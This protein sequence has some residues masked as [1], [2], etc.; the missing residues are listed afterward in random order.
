MRKRTIT[1]KFN[2]KIGPR[3]ALLKSLARALVLNERIETT[4][5]KAKQLSSFIEK[6]I[7]LAR[8]GDLSAIRQLRKVFS[9][10]VTNKLVKDIAPLYKDRE[11]GYTRITKLGQRK[12]D[13]SNMSII[14]LI[15]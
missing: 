5:A 15:K 13:G 11:G 6:K 4:D 14:E 8:K 2:R 7:T 10:D 9:E 12:S 3:K 1:R